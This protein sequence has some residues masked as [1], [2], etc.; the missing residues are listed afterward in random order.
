VLAPH[1]ACTKARLRAHP[2]VV[3]RHP[4]AETS[5]SRASQLSPVC[6]QPGVAQISAPCGTACA[7]AGAA[8]YRLWG[9]G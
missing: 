3:A 8:A 6:V 1:I 9:R 4:E 7:D 2:R 5:R